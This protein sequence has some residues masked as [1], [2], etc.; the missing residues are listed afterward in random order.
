MA[1]GSGESIPVAR[2][3]LK[4][5]FERQHGYLDAIEFGNLVQNIDS[6]LFLALVHQEFGGS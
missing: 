4:E 2:F 6:S 1:V 3:N 5:D